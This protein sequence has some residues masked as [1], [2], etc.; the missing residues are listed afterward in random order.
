MARV[1]E[2]IEGRYIKVLV[3][4]LQRRQRLP[5]RRLVRQLGKALRLE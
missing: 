1:C 2:T 5:E 3:E 4:Q